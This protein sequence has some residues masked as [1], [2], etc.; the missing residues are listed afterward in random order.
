LAAASTREHAML[1]QIKPPISFH[2]FFSAR[3]QCCTALDVLG[4]TSMLKEREDSCV[5]VQS[6]SHAEPQGRRHSR[7]RACTYAFD[8]TITPDATALNIIIVLP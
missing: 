3:H 4:L 7:S 2:T 5:W 8:T 6:L 1:L